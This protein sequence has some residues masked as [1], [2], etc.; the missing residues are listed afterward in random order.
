[1]Q[2]FR[3]LTLT[4]KQVLVLSVMALVT[5]FIGLFGVQSVRTGEHLASLANRYQ[6]VALQA[7]TANRLITAVVMDSRGIYMSTAPAEMERFAPALLGN[8]VKLEQTV[9]E[10]RDLIDPAERADFNKASALIAEF[11]KFRRELVRLGREVSIP[12][13]RAFGD[14]EANRR[15]RQA[16][17]AEVDRLSEKAEADGHRTLAE[18]EAYFAQRI[19]IFAALI[20][21]AIGAGFTVGLLM[22][23][24][25]IISP[26]KALTDRMGAMSDGTLDQPIEDGGR[27]D[28]I[29]AMLRSIEG[30]RVGLLRSQELARKQREAAEAEERRRQMTDRATHSFTGNID[31]ILVN[32]GKASERANGIARTMR[33]YA[34]HTAQQSQLVAG[35]AR[36]ASANVQTVA[37]AAEELS[38]SI[39]EIGRQVE[40][41]A[42]TTYRAVQEAE[43]TDKIVQ[44]L[45]QSAHHIGEVVTI[46]N[47]IAGQ[48]N[49]LALNATIEAARAG[50]AGKGFAV[51]ASEV[52]ALANQTARATEDIGQQVTQIR[53]ASD[54][55]AKAIHGIGEI[56]TEVSTIAGAIA[57]AVEQQ[58][59]ATSEIARNVQEAAR[60]AELMTD[61][62]GT[63]AKAAL[64]TGSAAEMMLESAG[65]LQAASV[66]IQKSVGTYVQEVKLAA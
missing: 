43:R 39:A 47:Q 42:A 36:Q 7:E 52:K 33:D 14:N 53:A 61:T 57:S 21:L 62:I 22:V 49:L 3:N 29:G 41:S 38:A 37:T 12:E 11:A 4:G 19:V 32:L 55:A 2:M 51:V 65:E 30:F 31:A 6:R 26:L 18:L 17:N 8:L 9:Q 63:M 35:T 1:M 66:G 24:R 40:Q 60:G 16:L 10:W 44:N 5:L 27:R 64:E 15:N 28:E 13:A 34:D 50:D 54:E 56:I 45:V 23:R 59:A 48:T 58:G 20:A 46:I 25:Q